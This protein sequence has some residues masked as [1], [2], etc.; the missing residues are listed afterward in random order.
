MRLFL[1]TV[2]TTAVLVV[3]PRSPD[4]LATVVGSTTPFPQALGALLALVLVAVALWALLV[5]G[6]STLGSTGTRLATAMT[7]RL[8][9]GTLL[10]ATSAALGATPAVAGESLDGLRLPERVTSEARD[11]VPP[12]TD[13]TRHD[14]PPGHDSP[15]ASTVQVRHGD[16]LWALVCARLGDAG[17][18]RV[19]HE[20][21][22]WHAVNRT[23]IGS[24]PDLLR[25]G[26]RLQVPEGSR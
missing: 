19:A 3:G 2:C 12:T 5:V 26:Q 17:P 1:L 15:Q 13:G 9:R 24:D 7:P 25:P 14:P 18:G 8:L 16:S 4:L 20:V 22:R 23:T 6:L 21:R 10:V 11:V